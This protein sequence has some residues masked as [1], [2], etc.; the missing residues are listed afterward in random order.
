MNLQNNRRYSEDLAKVI[1]SR[2]PKT[3]PAAR[4]TTTERKIHLLATE[5]IDGGELGGNRG[6][7]NNRPQ[8]HVNIGGGGHGSGGPQILMI[9]S[10]KSTEI[11]FVYF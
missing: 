5:S 3:T 9:G 8:N 1:R 11:F 2:D 4:K 10:G 6:K 7:T